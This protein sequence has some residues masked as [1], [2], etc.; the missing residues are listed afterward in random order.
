MADTDAY[1]DGIS[2]PHIIRIHSL[3]KCDDCSIRVFQCHNPDS[4]YAKMAVAS[5][6]ID[7]L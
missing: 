7:T 5:I 3:D 4:D 1:N 2:L 6:T